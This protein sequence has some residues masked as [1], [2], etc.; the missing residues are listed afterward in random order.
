MPKNNFSL[1]SCDGCRRPFITA[2]KF[3][4]FNQVR[5]LYSRENLYMI[6]KS[7][8]LFLVVPTEK[9]LLPHITKFCSPFNHWFINI[10]LSYRILFLSNHPIRHT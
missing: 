10:S 6:S 4:V 7:L 5:K 8:K 9:Q 1:N 3:M 2:K